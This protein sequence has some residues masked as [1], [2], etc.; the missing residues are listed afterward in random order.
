VSRPKT[1]RRALKDERP[2]DRV[3]PLIAKLRAEVFPS[4]DWLLLEEVPASTAWGG[5]RRIDALAVRLDGSWR[6]E[7]VEAKLEPRDLKT[8]IEHPEKIAPFCLFCQCVHLVV[9]APRKDVIR[10]EHLARLPEMW[11]I[12][13]VGAGPVVR[14]RPA[15]ERRNVEEPTRPF[16]HA[17]LRAAWAGGLAAGR[18]EMGAGA[19]ELRVVKEI[20][21]RFA[22]LSCEHRVLRP[23][24][25][26]VEPRLP[27]F[28]CAEER[29]TAS[30]ASWP[31]IASTHPARSRRVRARKAG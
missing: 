31:G 20:D 24:G 16:V 2:R 8:E 29:A 22:V 6:M 18:A 10:D 13:E 27:C 4:P 11:G 21:G 5:L 9:P 25:K 3:A 30:T 26:H 14:V 1:S 15:I 12:W 28:L 17:L 7:A 19:G 23:M